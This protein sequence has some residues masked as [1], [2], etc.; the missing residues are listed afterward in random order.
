MISVGFATILA[1][2]V[3]KTAFTARATESLLDL[4]RLAL[5]LARIFVERTSRLAHV[6]L[7]VSA[8]VTTP[9]GSTVTLAGDEVHDAPVDAGRAAAGTF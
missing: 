4:L 5:A 1:H 3:D 9:R 2:P 8:V 7:A 6:L